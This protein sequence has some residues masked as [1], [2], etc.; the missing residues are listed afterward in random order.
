VMRLAGA[1][2]TDQV[3]RTDNFHVILPTLE[4]KR[5]LCN[6]RNIKQ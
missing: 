6:K 5:Y 4:G 3:N 2:K 1:H